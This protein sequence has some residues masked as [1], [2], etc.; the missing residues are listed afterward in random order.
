MTVTYTYA[1]DQQNFVILMTVDEF[2][3]QVA[4][5]GLSDVDGYGHPVCCR[6]FAPDVVI[7]P[8]TRKQIPKNATHILWFQR[9]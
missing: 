6:F 4:D 9:R 7:R 2:H 1:L 3:K 8:S 5:R